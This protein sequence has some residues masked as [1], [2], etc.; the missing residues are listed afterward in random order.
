[1]RNDR[2]ANFKYK[3]QILEGRMIRTEPMTQ[4]SVFKIP[5]SNV[6][7][8]TITRFKRVVVS[9]KVQDE[10]GYD[11]VTYDCDTAVTIEPVEVTA[12]DLEKATEEQ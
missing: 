5:G 10:C 1:M 9:T 8:R 4:E 2:L 12:A 11:I 7:L 6:Q 3:D